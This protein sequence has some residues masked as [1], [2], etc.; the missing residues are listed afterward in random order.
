[1]IFVKQK[2]GS[3][4]LIS[5]DEFL[6]KLAPDLLPVNLKE[7]RNELELSQVDISKL[8]SVKPQ[9]YRNWEYGRTKV[10]RAMLLLLY[11]Q[12]E[13]FLRARRLGA[14]PYR[15]GETIEAQGPFV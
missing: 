1:M 15:N 5:K 14:S 13:R 4:K 3:L 7:F 10:P 6:K 12:R 8:I 9:T 2:D 11:V